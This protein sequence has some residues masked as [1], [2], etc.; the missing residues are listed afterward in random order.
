MDR[1]QSKQVL[2]ISDANPENIKLL[3]T[4]LSSD[5]DIKVAVDEEEVIRLASSPVTPELILLNNMMPSQMQ[6]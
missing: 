6:R 3:K 1:S 2:L 4:I 5:F